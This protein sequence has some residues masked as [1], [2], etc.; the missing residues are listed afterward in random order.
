VRFAVSGWWK[1]ETAITMP[2]FRFLGLG[3]VCSLEEEGRWKISTYG[4]VRIRKKRIEVEL[5]VSEPMVLGTAIRSSSIGSSEPVV[6][7]GIMHW[8]NEQKF[9]VLTCRT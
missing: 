9:I 4:D 1:I 6:G 2:P 5:A 3:T 7:F 8:S